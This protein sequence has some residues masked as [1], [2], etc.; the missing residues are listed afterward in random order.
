MQRAYLYVSSSI[1]DKFTGIKQNKHKHS[2]I[3]EIKGSLNSLISENSLLQESTGTL[4][5][6]KK[7]P[8]GK[9]YFFLCEYIQRK[10]VQT[11]HPR[12]DISEMQFQIV[13]SFTIHL[14][15]FQ[16]MCIYWQTNQKKN[17]FALKFFLQQVTAVSNPVV[18]PF[19]SKSALL[20]QEH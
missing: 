7:K 14:R 11:F 15:A 20:A 2:R 16:Y 19:L 18:L 8:V 9:Y 4:E 6:S 3:T 17:E 10:C 5:N 12:A 13:T 1:E